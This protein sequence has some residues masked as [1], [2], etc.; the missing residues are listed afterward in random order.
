VVLHGFSYPF[1]IEFPEMKNKED[2]LEFRKNAEKYFKVIPSWTRQK[3]ESKALLKK[4]VALGFCRF[5]YLKGNGFQRRRARDHLGL[6]CLPEGTEPR[7]YE[8]LL[9]YVNCA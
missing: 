6:I 1:L 5:K 4:Y 3:K 8:P 9:G 7:V 2:F